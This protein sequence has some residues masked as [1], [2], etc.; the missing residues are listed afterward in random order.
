MSSTTADNNTDSEDESDLAFSFTN[1]RRG[2]L[3]VTDDDP[4]LTDGED[5]FEDEAAAGVPS[6]RSREQYLPLSDE[7]EWPLASLSEVAESLLRHAGLGARERLPSPPP[8]LAQ[9][10]VPWSSR[11]RGQYLTGSAQGLSDNDEGD[12]S[13]GPASTASAA[14]VPWSQRMRGR[15]ISNSSD[16]SSSADEGDAG[17]AH[18]ARMRWATRGP[19]RGHPG[20]SAS[21]CLSATI[22]GLT[23]SGTQDEWPEGV[24]G[25]D[26]ADVQ[27]WGE[28]RR[29]AYLPLS[30]DP[31]WEDERTSEPE[32]APKLQGAP[33][34]FGGLVSQGPGDGEDPELSSS[35]RGIEEWDASTSKDAAKDAAKDP[36]RETPR[37]EDARAQPKATAFW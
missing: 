13:T 15:Y 31:C 16:V 14:G 36:S 30:D 24:T 23:N 7:E 21:L 34:G 5:D 9:A 26:M 22:S 17:S 10:S 2:A 29:E 20:Q 27:L 12:V 8:L 35:P 28:R 25:N 6:Q 33:G 1:R 18:L 37:R 4:D 3:T 11:V 19:I 32:A